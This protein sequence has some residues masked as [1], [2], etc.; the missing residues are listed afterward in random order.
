MFLITHYLAA[1][2]YMILSIW[3]HAG[4]IKMALI[5]K[6]TKSLLKDK[7]FCSRGRGHSV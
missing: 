6:P 3:K 5:Q 7:N 4:V 1:K 2:D